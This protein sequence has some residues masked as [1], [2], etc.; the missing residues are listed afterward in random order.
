MNAFEIRR[1]ITEDA[2]FITNSWMESYRKS[3][4]S[5]YIPKFIYNIG[6]H[7]SVKSAI[8]SSII[9]V[10]VAKDDKNQIFGWICIEPGTTKTLH[11]IYVKHAFRELG[12]GGA[13]LEES[14][15]FQEPFFFSH[16]TKGKLSINL[17][18]KGKY[19]PYKFFKGEAQ[20]D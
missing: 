11:Y 13:L 18:E 7:A 10:A 3:D 17:F 15:I 5:K 6:H 16:L 9:Y 2:N 8:D 4:F 14:K 1:G 12:I 19:N 20:Y